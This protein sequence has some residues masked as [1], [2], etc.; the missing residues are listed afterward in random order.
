MGATFFKAHGHGNDYV[1]F[2]PGN[3]W[4]ATQAA[5]Q[6]VCDPHRGIGADGIVVVTDSEPTTLRMFNPDGGEF[7]RS[8]NGL[9]VA[10]VAL[11]RW[12]IEATNV[13]RVLV[14]GSEVPME[15]GAFDRSTGWDVEAGL[16]RARVGPTAIEMDPTVLDA[17]GR[18]AHPVVGLLDVVPVSVGNPHLVV[19]TE[20]LS[21]AALHRL[22][23]I[24]ATH[25]SIANG[26]NVQLV[27]LDGEGVRIR[28]WER[29]VGPTTASGT[30]ASA[31]AVALVHSRRLPAGA[32]TIHMDGGDFTVG[33]DALLDVTLQGPIQEIADGVLSDGFL[34]ALRELAPG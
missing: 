13:M 3:D 4:T 1:V 15:I 27:R 12:E 6:R 26:T 28:I 32:H 9:R 14:A 7:E 8:G 31:V 5:V 18:L 2:Q 20:D 21:D 34:A 11:R 10:A 30:S 29:G 24:L 23:P 17:E 16:G 22:G 19:F 33:V 25:P